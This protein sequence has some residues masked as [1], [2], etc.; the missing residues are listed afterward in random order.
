MTFVELRNNSTASNEAAEGPTPQKVEW[1]ALPMVPLYHLI[2]FL[3]RR[4]RYFGGGKAFT[5]VLIKVQ[6][7]K[8]S[9]VLIWKGINSYRHRRFFATYIDASSFSV[10]WNIFLTLNTVIQ[11]KAC[12]FLRRYNWRRAKFVSTI[13]VL[14]RIIVILTG[15]AQN[16]GGLIACCV[17]LGLGEAPLIPFPVNYITQGKRSRST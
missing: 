17:L 13:K 14:S 12:Q 5:T 4:A 11:K 6:C 8:W 9:L 15:L 2:S 7:W 10:G 16:H 1:H 3:D